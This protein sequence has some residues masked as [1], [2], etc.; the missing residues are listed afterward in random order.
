MGNE[1]RSQAQKFGVDC[2]E[3]GYIYR[4][5]Y[6]RF[7]ADK[8]HKGLKPPLFARSIAVKQPDVV[9]RCLNQIIINRQG[10]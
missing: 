8:D 7:W 3:L 6:D 2:K 1:I 9:R 5:A 4:Y 10:G